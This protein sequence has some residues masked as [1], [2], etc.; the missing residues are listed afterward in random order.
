MKKSQV[1]NPKLLGLHYAI[2]GGCQILP[3]KLEV[4][5]DLYVGNWVL[6]LF[7]TKVKLIVVTLKKLTIWEPQQ[8][9][10]QNG[11]HKSFSLSWEWLPV[12][13]WWAT[14]ECPALLTSI[15]AQGKHESATR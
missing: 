10:T 5:N 11:E 13:D 12:S 14:K 4:I 7:E 2:W 1:S 15:S 6:M 9:H 3:K 8:L